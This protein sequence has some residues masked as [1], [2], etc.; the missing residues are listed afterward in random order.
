MAL[1]LEYEFRTLPADKQIDTEPFL[2]AVT[3]LPP[4][5]GE[6][7]PRIP[8]REA[9]RPAGLAGSRAEKGR[10]GRLQSSHN[11]P[12]G[13]GSAAQRSRLRAG[14]GV[15]AKGRP[16]EDGISLLTPVRPPPHP[17]GRCAPALEGC[18]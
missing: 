3:H 9:P 18:A 14:G 2:E 15:A 13:E 17:P 8:G 11:S 12:A 10:E 4:F 16:R 1:L 6:W 5:F 7:P